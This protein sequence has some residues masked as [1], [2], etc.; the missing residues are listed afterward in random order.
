MPKEMFV[1]NINGWINIL[2]YLK[3]GTSTIASELIN[4]FYSKQLH[5]S[6]KDTIVI[7]SNVSKCLCCSFTKI[8]YK[9]IF[10]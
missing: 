8:I 1:T 9:Y 5:S 7:F 2:F 6:S 3:H 10:I 4:I